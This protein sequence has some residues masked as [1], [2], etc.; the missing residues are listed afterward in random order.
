MTTDFDRIAASTRSPYIAPGFEPV[1]ARLQEMVE[2]DPY[3]SAQFC[4]YADGKV[5]VDIWGGHDIG[6]DTIQGI[7]SSTKGIAG[8]S[9][10]L[11]VERGLLE[12]D[13]LMSHYWP[14]FA[15]G[16][17]DS[18]TVRTA[19]SHRVGVPGVEPQVTQS[20][21]IDHEYMASRVAAQVPHWYPGSAHGYHGLT[22][23]TMM[24]ELVRRIDGRSVATFFRQEIGDPRDVDVYIGTHESEER[25]VVDVLPQHLTDEQ[26]A[27]MAVSPIRQ[28]GDT[29]VGM[30]FNRAVSDPMSE[31]ISNNR[32]ARAA[33]QASAGGVGSAR[34]LARLY[35]N[36]IGEVDGKPALLSPETIAAFSQIHAVGI[37]LILGL[38]TRFGIVF[39]K[40]DQDR[41]RIGSHAS[42]GHDGAGGAIGVADP[43]HALAY[44]YVPRRM[45]FPGGADARGMEL[46]RIVRECLATY[47]S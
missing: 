3:Y 5:V 20:E 10:A 44:G 27:I 30:A 21:L 14:E 35:A 16:G 8:I 42:F 39:Q 7:F 6:A 1:S 18:V 47:R 26:A 46:A 40:P 43:W 19:L 45:S 34:G 9:V 38:P 28:G 12:L 2:E 22:I 31:L 37:D 41:L 4:A 23:G 36:A 17:K 29:L 11:L 13:R 32:A 15:Q 25:R 33:G 24:D